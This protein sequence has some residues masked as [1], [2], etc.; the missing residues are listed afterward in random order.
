MKMP[1][2]TK[3]AGFSTAVWWPRRALRSMLVIH[4]AAPL[5]LAPCPAYGVDP[6]GVS[7]SDRLQRAARNT[8]H[9]DAIAV[10]PHF[11][12]RVRN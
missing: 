2:P 8:P 11:I 3:S 4:I 12:P 1:P 10:V 9:P 6:A 7:G 5:A